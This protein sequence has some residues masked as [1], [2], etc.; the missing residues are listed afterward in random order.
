MNEVTCFN[1]N[2]SIDLV[3]SSY[4]SLSSWDRIIDLVRRNNSPIV[5]SLDE[6]TLLVVSSGVSSGVVDYVVV[7]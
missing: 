7:E 1:N 6:G 5:L 4:P 3:V 2:L